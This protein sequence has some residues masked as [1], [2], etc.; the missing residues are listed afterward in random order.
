LIWQL[1]RFVAAMQPKT[2]LMENVR[3]LVSAAIRHRPIKLRPSHG[4]KPLRPDERPGS[5]L[6]L[7]AKDLSRLRP[8]YRLD[9]F[10]V[11]AVNYGAPQLRERLLLVGNRYGEAVTFPPP[12]HGQL[13]VSGL[14]PFATLGDVIKGVHD[15]NPLLMDFSPRKKRYL[16]MVPPGGNWRALPLHIARYSMGRAYLAKGGRSGWWRRLSYDL[17]CPTIVTMPNHASTSLC[18]PEEVRVLTVR[19]CALVQE[20]PP[21]WEFAG[22]SAQEQYTQ[23]GNAVPVRLGVVAGR[24]LVDLLERIDATEGKC[25]KA[26]ELRDS[27]TVTYIR[28]HVRTRR[29]FKAGETFVWKDGADN[30]TVA[31]APMK[32]EEARRTI[33]GAHGA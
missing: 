22:R 27:L 24:V 19:E 15:E 32:T 25:R 5:V 2:F 33:T 23:V 4:G 11:N 13:A 9:A 14:L 1:V 7:L 18:H 26:A 10:E 17:P 16:S 8:S 20:F 12:T 6:R 3:G 21:D 30:S 29:W 31:H 28:S